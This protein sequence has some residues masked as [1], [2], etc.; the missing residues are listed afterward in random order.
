[1][2]N[3]DIED[4]DS[5]SERLTQVKSKNALIDIAVIKFPVCPILRISMCL[6]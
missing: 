3:V 6:S 1:M 2:M 5:L 4:E